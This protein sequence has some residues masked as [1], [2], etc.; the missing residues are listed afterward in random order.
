MGLQ[1]FARSL[2]AA[3]T[4]EQTTRQMKYMSHWFCQEQTK[5]SEQQAEA[6]LHGF[7][8]YRPESALRLQCREGILV[9]PRSLE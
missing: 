8:H 9:E 1:G 7:L 3:L 5:G 6:Q 4:P 2:E